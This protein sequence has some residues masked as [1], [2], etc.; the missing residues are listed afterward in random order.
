M[1]NHIKI[2]MNVGIKTQDENMSGSVDKIN[3]KVCLCF[4]LSFLN[5][6]HLYCYFLYIFPVP[7]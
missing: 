2:T 4:F 1:F 6:P 5:Y 3:K 7:F